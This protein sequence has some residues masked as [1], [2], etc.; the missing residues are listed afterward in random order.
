MDDLQISFP[1][2]STDDARA[3]MLV[4]QTLCRCPIS[5]HFGPKFGGYLLATLSLKKL[6]YMMEIIRKTLLIL[7]K[8]T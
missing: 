2:L 5:P 8:L 7:S 1:G 3:M 4:K 6:I